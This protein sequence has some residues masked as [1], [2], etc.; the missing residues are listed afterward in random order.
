MSASSEGDNFTLH[1]LANLAL[2]ALYFGSWTQVLIVVGHAFSNKRL[3]GILLFNALHVLCSLWILREVISEPVHLYMQLAFF[4]DGFL[5]VLVYA[6]TMR[7]LRKTEYSVEDQE[8]IGAVALLSKIALYAILIYW[9]AR[10]PWV[11]QLLNFEF[12]DC[13]NRWLLRFMAYMM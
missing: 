13:A 1:L 4:Y 3:V 9:L 12:L 11:A 10:I 8:C 6:L 2:T 5:K 7:G